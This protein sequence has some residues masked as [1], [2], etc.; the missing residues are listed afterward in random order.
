MWGLTTVARRG[1]GYKEP[2]YWKRQT[3]GPTRINDGSIPRYQK[4]VVWMLQISVDAAV[5]KTAYG[6]HPPGQTHSKT[7][8][9]ATKELKEIK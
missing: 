5:K 7:Y 2:G 1:K 3:Q 8:D 6:R 4:S 9:S